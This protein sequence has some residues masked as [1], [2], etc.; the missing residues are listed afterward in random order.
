M[1]NV[2]NICLKYVNIC[3]NMFNVTNQVLHMIHIL[4]KKYY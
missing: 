4:L 2:T 3:K 1:F